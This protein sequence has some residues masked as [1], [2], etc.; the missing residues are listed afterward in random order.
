MSQADRIDESLIR[1]APEITNYLVKKGCRNVAVLPFRVQKGDQ[2]P[3]FRGGLIVTNMV[4]R[5]QHSLIFAANPEVPPIGIANFAAK[6]GH[7]ASYRTPTDRKNLFKV[8]YPL[9]WGCPPPEVPI[10][11]FLTGK[12][13][14]STDYRNTTVT[15]EAIDRTA[16]ITPVTSF[17]VK[18]DRSILADLGRGYSVT[19]TRLSRGVPPAGDIV[20]VE[21]E[22][23]APAS[24]SKTPD[25]KPESKVA[26][27]PDA[28]DSSAAPDSPTKEVLSVGNAGKPFPVEW[29][30][31]YDGAAQAPQPDPENPGDRNFIIR[32]P[33]PGQRVTFGVKNTG[34]SPIGLVL[35]VNG[36]STLYEDTGEPQQMR[37]WVLAPGKQCMIEGFHQQDGKTCIPIVGFEESATKDILADLGS[38]QSAGLIQIFVIQPGSKG[39]QPMALSRSMRRPSRDDVPAGP[40]KSLEDLQR[41]LARS[42]SLR[43]SRGLMAGD[44]EHK[45]ASGLNFVEFQSGPP[46]DA[47]VIRYYSLP[48]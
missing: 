6:K 27:S 22:D 28:T 33:K 46:C 23:P 19:K 31:C 5:L 7:A 43:S 40:A 4:D 11:I 20:I 12:V 16:K 41:N 13:A 3:Q 9:L 47:L 24:Q 26:S 35:T 21:D 8:N 29:S 18:S 32:D 10:D 14:V 1:R 2:L 48:K 42:A 37:P 17:S 45:K 25:S 30:V 34:D 38:E 44:I 15:I 36:V 39:S